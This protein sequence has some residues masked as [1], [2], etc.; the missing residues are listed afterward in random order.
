M[1]TQTTARY[2]YKLLNRLRADRKARVDAAAQIVDQAKAE[3]RELHPTEAEAVDAAMKAVDGI[4]AQI[5]DQ[6]AAMMRAVLGG[7]SD[8]GDE[9]DGVRYLSLRTPRLKA[10]IT[11]RIGAMLGSPG[12]KALIADGE[13]V[14]TI[15]MDS[16]VYAEG[17]AP[18][19]LI[20]VLPTIERPAVY[21]YMRQTARDNNAAPVAPGALKPTSTYG[22]TAVERRLHVI[23][24]V[25]EPIDKYVLQDGPSLATFVQQEMV[26][27]L[28]QAVETQIVS[29]DGLGENLTG[30]AN[31]SGIQTQAYSTSPVLTARAAVTKVEVLGFAPAWYVLNPL[32]WERVETATLGGGQY[33]LNAEGSRSGV[34]VDSAARRLWGVGVTVSTAVPSGTG[35]LLSNGAVQL[36][37]N[38]SIETEMSSNVG[39]SFA[40]NQVVLRVEGRFDLAVTRPLGVVQMDLT[41]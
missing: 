28:H 41:A 20:E 40:R 8:R 15:P 9:N 38:G 14:A 7:P 39:D 10:D 32:D 35:Y 27:G 33:V 6:S 34:P 12:M 13:P 25:S 30:L 4:D 3:N 17:I 24:H 26:A 16:E 18:T 5:A 23:A 31:T 21:R 1:T 22:L 11:S 19:S 37:T 29:G 36:V 2:D